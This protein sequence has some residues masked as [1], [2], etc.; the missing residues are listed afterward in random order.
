MTIDTCSSYL[1]LFSMRIYSNDTLYDECLECGAICLE[2]SK[3]RMAM[4]MGT[5]LLSIDQR[6]KFEMICEPEPRPTTDPTDHPTNDL[7]TL[8]PSKV[9]TS[10][11]TTTRP[12]TQGIV[13]NVTVRDITSSTSYL[14][15]PFGRFEASNIVIID[16]PHGVLRYTV[17]DC[18][19]CFIWQYR[20]AEE[21]EW[22]SFDVHGNDDISVEI[23]KFGD[24]YTSIL[25]VQSIRRLNA[26]N[27]V[28]DELKAHHPFQVGT[29]YRFRMKFEIENEGYSVSGISNEFHFVT[30]SLPVGGKCIVQNIDNVLPLEPYNLFCDFWETE[31]GT[32]LEYNALIGDVTMSTDGFVDDARELRGIAPS[33]VVSITVLVKEQNEYNAITCYPIEATFK[34]M[35]EILGNI[36]ANGSST[37][38]VDDFLSTINN[39]TNS[40]ALSKTPNVAVAIHSVVE[41]LYENNFTSQNDAEQIVDDMVVNILQTSTV[42][43]PS[44]ESTSNISGNAIITELATVSSIT[45]NEEIVDVESTTTQLV[46]EYLPGVFDAV[47]LFIDISTNNM[48]SNSSSFEIQSALYSIAGQSQDLIS[49]L[50][51]T[52]GGVITK[53]NTTNVAEEEIDSVNSLS[54]SLVDFATFAASTALAHSKIGETFNYKA[55]ELDENGTVSKSKVVTAVKF[56]AYNRTSKPPVCGSGPQNIKLP[57]TFMERNLGIFD[58]AVMSSTFDPFVPKTD[59]GREQQSVDVFTANIYESRRLTAAVEFTTN[60]CFPY[61]ITF[62][63][64]DSSTFDLNMTLDESSPF[65][66][67]DFWNTNE[68]Y[69]DSAGCYVYN[70]TNDSVICGCTHLTTFS[71]SSSDFVPRANTLTNIGWKDL[72]ASNLW[73]Y[74]TVWLTCLLVS[75]LFL[76]LCYINPRSGTVHARSFLGLFWISILFVLTV[77]NRCLIL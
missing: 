48:S 40:T 22:H 56:A 77:H 27:C 62:Q 23:T 67:C 43:S 38:L 4:T 31:N 51:D 6:H 34:S 45:S 72:T 54:E 30:N 66:S 28:D 8:T 21:N 10:D 41:N 58:C 7:L 61:L 65:P 73:R 44:N 70:I 76:A 55:A 42:I 74:P 20:S 46:E 59:E 33:G 9:P 60:E 36:S 18:I 53:H 49:N 37:E 13:V 57:M 15:D 69:W 17:V 35:D 3:F 2:E 52:L 16:D 64:S 47:D 75:I 71:V 25:V 24:E 1:N 50:E 14:S 39:I 63:M 32:D 11:P 26:G 29:E 12:T 68:S 19:S 5:Y